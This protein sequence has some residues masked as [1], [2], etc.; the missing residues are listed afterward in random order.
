MIAHSRECDSRRLMALLNHELADEAEAIIKEHLDLCDDCRAE[1]DALTA[2]SP[3]WQETQKLLS[4]SVHLRS[5]TQASSE[6]TALPAATWIKSLLEVDPSGASLGLLHSKPVQGVIGQGG[7]GVVLKVWDASLQRFLA[8]K[9]MSPLLAS[10]GLARQRFMREAQAVAAVV[11]PNIVPIYD[12]NEVGTIPFLVMPFVPGGN[13]QQRIDREGALP[14]TDILSIAGQLAEALGAAHQLGLVHRDIKPANVLLDEGGHRVMLSDFGLARALDDATMTG[15]GMI[16]GTPHYMSPEQARGESLDGRSDLYGLGA[17]IYTM[18][19]GKPPVQGETV[20]AVLRKIGEEPPKPIHEMNETMPLWLDGLVRLFLEKN[21]ESRVPDADKACE[22][23]R[24]CLAHLR[25]PGRNDLP[26]EVVKQ[27]SRRFINLA[28]LIGLV[29]L[30][31]V[32]VFQAYQTWSV[33][34]RAANSVMI[35]EDQE[36]S[37]RVLADQVDALR[38]DVEQDHY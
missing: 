3:W 35:E 26:V 7:M 29:A 20:L 19:T 25:A 1:L 36:A 34:D 32:A 12:V 21:P 27:D 28:Y 16:A 33:Q 17:V 18:A 5:A 10:S 15:S 8:V 38:A 2:A 23:I 11:H 9:L 24:R 6:F 14:I 30:M 4:D 31:I 22:L 37:L 13:L